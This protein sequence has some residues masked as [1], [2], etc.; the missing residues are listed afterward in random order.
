M[1]DFKS[2]LLRKASSANSSDTCIKKFWWMYK[3]QTIVE[4]NSVRGAVPS[5]SFTAAILILCDGG[6]RDKYFECGKWI[7][8]WYIFRGRRQKAITI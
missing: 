4:L 6:Q 1:F 8:L 2:V 3:K 7:M 5:H